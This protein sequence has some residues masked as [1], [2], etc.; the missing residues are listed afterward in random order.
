MGQALANYRE[1]RDLFLRS[2][3]SL[4]EGYLVH[5]RGGRVLLCNTGAERLLGVPAAALLGREAL[6]PDW[7]CFSESGEIISRA[8]LPG[9]RAIETALPQES[10]V[11]GIERPGAPRAWLSVRA[12]PVF[13]AGGAS[14]YAAVLTFADITAEKQT[15]EDLRK[16]REFQSAMLESLQSGVV[17]CDAAGVLA[18]FNRAA[19][20][21]HGIPEEALPAEEWADR[22]DLFRADGV[23]PLTTGEIPLFRA[24]GGETVRDA[25]MVIAPAGRPDRIVLASGQAIYDG[26]G[27]KL[28]AVVAMHDI[29]ARRR[30]EQEL[31]RL[32]SIVASSEEAI[33]A[34]TLDGTLVSWNA[35]AERLYGYAASEVIGCHAS[36]LASPGEA[37]P[38]DAVIPRLLRGESLA[39]VE[40]VRHRRDG[41]VLNL[42]LTFSP[43]RSGGGEV[44]GV[45]CIARD[46]TAQRQAEDALR[47]SEARLRYLSDAAFEGI[48]VSQNGVVLDANPAFLSLYGYTRDQVI[49]KPG[50]EFTV[51]EAREMVRRKVMDGDEAAYEVECLRRDSST[52]HAEVRGRKV[53][54]NGQA[55]RVTAVRDISERR[56]M[57]EALQESRQF[58]HSIAENSASI[59]FVFDLETQS[60]VYSNRDVAEFLGCTPAEI[61]AAGGSLLPQIIHPDDLPRLMAHLAEFESAEDGA[62]ME[63]EYRAK[64]AS[65]EWRWIWNREVVF[66][67]GPDGIPRQILGN[68]QD[69]TERRKIEEALRRS[70]E[71]MRAV[72]SSAPVILYAADTS[73]TI[74]LSEGTGLAALGLVPGEAV[75]RSVNEFI[76]GD[77]TVLENTERALAGETVSCDVHFGAL[78]LHMAL[79]P[80]RDQS[81][82][83]CGII[84]VSFDITERAQ[85]EE[86]FR[87]L[88][89]QSSN[90]HLLFDDGGIIDCN[91]AAVA[92]MRCADKSALMGLH[93]VSF[94]PERQFD[95]R[96]SSEKGAE[97]IALARQNGSHHFEWTRRA[98]DGTEFPVEVMLTE[99]RLS[100]KPVLLS[101]WHDLSGQKE[102]AQQ[103]KDYMVIL[104]F[105]KSQLE[106]T[107]KEL[108]T[109]ATTDGL[110][111]LKNR[112]TFA[113]KLAEEH[114]R[115]VRY[116]QPLSLLLLD[117]DHFKQYNDAYGHP[118]GD[119][120]LQG[121]AEALGRTARDTD[122]AARYGGEEFAVILPFTDEAGSL[123][124]AER[125]RAAIAAGDWEKRPITVSV[126][127]GTLSLDTPT[128]DSLTDCADAALYQSKKSGRNR[129]THGNPSAPPIARPRAPRAERPAAAS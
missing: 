49:G 56:R 93:P 57:E 67:R 62:V 2:I 64:H 54:W 10:V 99:V 110:T 113:A 14:P 4:Q 63:F 33:L 122:L 46:V 115:A 34:A 45:S 77:P 70:E 88:F 32:A 22:F 52:F 3:N 92:M 72:L 28:G 26:D 108:E 59:I 75:G 85:S 91:P 80:Q 112:R 50:G 69:V 29:T 126:G 20:D 111:G 71:T 105:Q 7:D 9:V 125:V 55:A 120:V 74:T 18:L 60:N 8:E 38:L 27:R 114:A 19:R 53:L 116:H 119:A 129:V 25:E 117:V 94:S 73:G 79:K 76:G 58:A 78:C 48:A 103:I 100:D 6:R 36:V 5:D 127:V 97:M 124:I 107:N 89:E 109:L 87:V 13:H 12:A 11:L 118:A 35:G 66:K 51:P 23:T 90:A 96:L 102:A 95:G 128:P 83:V 1:S 106:E 84:G 121:V 65:G 82:E 39:P 123:V 21:F 17:A 61:A 30:A 37:T 24:Y 81:G 104:E 15:Q 42:A 47:E 68:A 16:E 31:S 86:R 44:I 43:I 98:A 101:V 40:V 41:V